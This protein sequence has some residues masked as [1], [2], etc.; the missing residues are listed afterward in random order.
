MLRTLAREPTWRTGFVSVDALDAFAALDRADGA[1][2]L[3]GLAR[4]IE[5]ADMEPPLPAE[6]PGPAWSGPSADASRSHG[7]RPGGS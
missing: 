3:E 2:L 4:L 6:P 7:K 1:A 5:E